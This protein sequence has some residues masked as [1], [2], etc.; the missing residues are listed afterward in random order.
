MCNVCY[1]RSETRQ[2]FFLVFKTDFI[3]HTNE[4]SQK[5]GKNISSH[6]KMF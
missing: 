6:L 4:N 5:R 1:F 2:S 3:N